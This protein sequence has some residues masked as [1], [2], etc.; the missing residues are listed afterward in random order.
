M[1]VG[2]RIFIRERGRYWTLVQYRAFIL[3]V[4]LGTTLVPHEA[5]MFLSAGADRGSLSLRET[6]RQ[7]EDW[8]GP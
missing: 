2:M 8:P 6:A 5:R 3:T 1:I 4:C 7:V